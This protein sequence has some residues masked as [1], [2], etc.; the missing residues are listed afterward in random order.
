M[1]TSA[2]ETMT[3][4]QRSIVRSKVYATLANRVKRGEDGPFSAVD[5]FREICD[6]LA[7]VEVLPPGPGGSR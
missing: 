2:K 5:L 7:D 4:S 1:Q 6:E 3:D